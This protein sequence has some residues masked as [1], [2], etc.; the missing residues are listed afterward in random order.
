M[1][2]MKQKICSCKRVH[3]E[4][5]KSHQFEDCLDELSGLYWNCECGSTLFVPVSEIEFENVIGLEKV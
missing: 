3:A 4:I 1:K 5:P 2:L